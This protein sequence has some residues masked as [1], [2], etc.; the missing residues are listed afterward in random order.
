MEGGGGGGGGGGGF[1][2]DSVNGQCIEYS[3]LYIVYSCCL[4]SC[5]GLLFVI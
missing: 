5:V 3:T 4:L 2:C 1:A